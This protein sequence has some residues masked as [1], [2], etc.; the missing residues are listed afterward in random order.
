MLD[1]VGS[2]DREQ[3]RA[4]LRAELERQARSELAEVQSVLGWRARRR[5]EKLRRSKADQ[6]IPRAGNSLATEQTEG[7]SPR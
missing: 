3:E 7:I 2:R 1:L 5:L 4:D 6:Q